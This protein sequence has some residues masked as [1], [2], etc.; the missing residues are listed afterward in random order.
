VFDEPAPVL[1]V[2]EFMAD[3]ALTVEALLAPQHH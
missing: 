2:P 3:W 1:P